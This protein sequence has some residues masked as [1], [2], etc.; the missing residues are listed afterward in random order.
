MRIPRPPMLSR[1]SSGPC[2]RRARSCTSSRAGLLSHWNTGRKAAKAFRRMATEGTT[3][4]VEGLVRLVATGKSKGFLTYDEVNDALPADMVS[5]D[6]LDD[7]MMLFG[8]M[9]IELVDSA[10]AARMPSEVR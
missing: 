9:D 7:V 5:L 3:T 8:S 1:T 10:K 6:Q 2:T 4:K